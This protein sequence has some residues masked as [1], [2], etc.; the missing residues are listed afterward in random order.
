MAG[1]N[2][3][4]QIDTELCADSVEWCPHEDFSNFFINGTYQ[5]N[6]NENSSANNENK[7]SGF[8]QLFEIN[9]EKTDFSKHDRIKMPGIL[10]VKWCHCSLEKP[11]FASADAEGNVTVYEL[12]NNKEERLRFVCS[13][14]NDISSIALSL[15]WSCDSATKSEPLIASSYSNGEVK[16]KKLADYGLQ[17]ITTWKAHDFEAWIC[18][19]DNY[20]PNVLYTGGDDC[21]FKGWDTRTASSTFTNKTH[22]MGVCSMHSSP[23]KEYI[24]ATG[25]YDEHVRLWDTRFIKRVPLSSTSA[26]GGVWRLKW[27][28]HDKDLLLAACMHNGFTVLNCSDVNAASQSTVIN[29]KEHNSLAYGAD[30]CFSRHLE[31]NDKLV[32]TC[33]FYDHKLCVWSFTQ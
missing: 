12:L 27:S 24:F 31:S 17:T 11:L 30:W 19:F 23:Y 5:L 10:D 16:I 29:F 28:P 13:T 8:L 14:A 33:S 2:L 7:R 9:S 6:T 4:F 1:F 32:A 22:E 21:L 26:G 15:S 20:F 18:A 25:S 3:Y